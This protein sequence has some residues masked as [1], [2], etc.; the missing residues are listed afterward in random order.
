MTNHQAIRAVS[1]A[2]WLIMESDYAYCECGGWDETLVS[3][4]GSV[5]VPARRNH[6]HR[7]TKPRA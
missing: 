3:H 1:S 5:R 4:N 2:G 6:A 7:C